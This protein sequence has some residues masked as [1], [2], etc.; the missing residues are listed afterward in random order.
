MNLSIAL[1]EAAPASCG[2]YKF[3]GLY[4]L[5][6]AV[7]W[8]PRPGPRFGHPAVRSLVVPAGRCEHVRRLPPAPRPTRARAGNAAFRGGYVGVTSRQVAPGRTALARVLK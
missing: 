7:S 1:K 3:R 5:G 4:L 6:S 8:V 2:T